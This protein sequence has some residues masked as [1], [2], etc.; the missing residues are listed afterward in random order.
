M[1]HQSW[2]TGDATSNTFQ[3]D[4][5]AL[6]LAPPL[7][8]AELTFYNMLAKAA[9]GTEPT[10]YDWIEEELSQITLTTAEALD[11]TET[12]ITFSAGEIAAAGLRAGAILAN[13]T[14][15]SSDSIE[16]MLVTSVDNSTTCT[17]V[18]NYG[19]I[20]GSGEGTGQAHTSGDKLRIVGYLNF[21]GSSATKTDYFV[22]RDRTNQYNTYSLVDDWTQITGSDMVRIYRGSHPDNWS[23]QVQGLIQRLERQFEWQLLRSPRV[24]RSSTARGSMGGVIWWAKNTTGSHV[25]TTSE[26]FDYEKVDDGL[27]YLYN[28]N[29]LDSINPVLVVPPTG[30]QAAAYIHESAMRMEYMSET[31]RGLQTNSFMSTLTGKRVP[32][33]ISQSL[34]DDTFLILNLQA[35]R[36]HFLQGRALKVY[37]KPLGQELDDFQAQRWISELTM[38]FQRPADNCYYHTNVSYTRPS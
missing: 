34:P 22:K 24:A 32:V 36:V 1:A 11:T 5:S 20:T 9:D 14:D 12:D 3:D 2:Y 23:Y 31:V 4:F 18:R 10:R 26:T 15:N 7:P 6:V 33:V 16:N 13:A 29:G 35:V 28:Q 21:E 8:G 25:V 27:L 17:V 37:T 38:E 30:A 19:D